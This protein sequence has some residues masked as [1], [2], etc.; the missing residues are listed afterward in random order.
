MGGGRTVQVL[1]GLL[2]ALL[3][4]ACEEKAAGLD[5]EWILKA[6]WGEGGKE[7]AGRFPGARA[8]EEQTGR[9]LWLQTE[10][11]DLPAVVGL[12]FSPKGL[13]A[14]EVYA[15]AE[16]VEGVLGIRKLDSTTERRMPVSRPVERFVRA[17]ERRL[18]PPSARHVMGKGQPL[19]PARARARSHTVL[20]VWQ[21]ARCHVTLAHHAL[22]FDGPI[23]LVQPPR[24]SFAG[25]PDGAQG[26]SPAR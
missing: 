21:L 24:S 5:L 1:S 9:S 11:A 18:G 6:P 2:W 22:H 15:G 26:E 17:L 20:E 10:I 19:P 23:L 4:P 12:L 25:A 14:V 7:I 8:V 3:L 16:D 13:S